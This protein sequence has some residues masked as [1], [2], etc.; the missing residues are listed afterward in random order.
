MTKFFPQSKLSECATFIDAPLIVF[1]PQRL[2]FMKQ[3]H[4]G[5]P[6]RHTV[7]DIHDHPEAKQWESKVEV[8]N[9]HEGPP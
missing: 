7:N 3:A 8:A 9:F 2:D 1:A 6:S 5:A 4:M